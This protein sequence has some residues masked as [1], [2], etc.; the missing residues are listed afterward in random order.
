M[1]SVTGTAVR[2][3]AVTTAPGIMCALIS[4]GDGVAGS[5]A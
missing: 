3:M 5:A 1:A 2:S 4:D